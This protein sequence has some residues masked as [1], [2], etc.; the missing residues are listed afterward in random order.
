MN[1]HLIARIKAAWDAFCVDP[2]TVF[3]TTMPTAASLPVFA[4][5]PPPLPTVIAVQRIHQQLKTDERGVTMEYGLNIVLH[6]GVGLRF[7]ELAVDGTELLNQWIPPRSEFD[8]MPRFT[9]TFGS[10][11]LRADVLDGMAKNAPR[12]N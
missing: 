2:R 6:A 3:T 9:T 1:L 5:E 7:I 4:P 10:E 11:F 8:A 12:M